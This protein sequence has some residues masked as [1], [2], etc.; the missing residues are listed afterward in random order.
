MLVGSAVLEGVAAVVAGA[1]KVNASGEAECGEC[2]S[3]LS[4]VAGGGGCGA[5]DWAASSAGPGDDSGDDVSDDTC[6]I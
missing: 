3:H 4:C 1:S 2:G 5:C 6:G